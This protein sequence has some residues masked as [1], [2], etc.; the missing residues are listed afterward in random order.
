MSHGRVCSSFIVINAHETIVGNPIRDLVPVFVER[1]AR[2]GLSRSVPVAPETADRWAVDDPAEIGGRL[3]TRC[4]RQCPVEASTG[5]T[6][7][8]RM[9]GD[10]AL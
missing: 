7:S 3:D 8:K 9:P 4:N 2:V 5:S 10:M 6:R 1:S